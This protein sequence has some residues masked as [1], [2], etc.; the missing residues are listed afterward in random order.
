MKRLLISILVMS[1][2]LSAAAQVSTI[3]QSLI[4]LCGC[5]MTVEACEGA[6][7]CTSAA[8]IAASVEKMVAEGKTNEEVLAAFVEA[9]GE[10]VLAAPTKKGL[11]LTAWI[12]PFVLT[13]TAAAVLYLWISRR[14]RQRKSSPPGQVDRRRLND[15][16]RYEALL[17]DELQ[18]YDL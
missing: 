15:E 1:F 7:T 18:N 14:T 11:N 16:P 8:K 4:C 9:Y 2:A 17:N 6:M 13:L 10:K 12:L 5:G 3:K